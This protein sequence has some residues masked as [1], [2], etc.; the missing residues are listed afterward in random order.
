VT[1]PRTR[2]GFAC[3]VAIAAL[4]GMRSLASEPF[5]HGLFPPLPDVN[6]AQL[7]LEPERDMRPLERSLK[8]TAA[9]ARE[10]SSSPLHGT[11]F[12]VADVIGP[13]RARTIYVVPQY[14]RSPTSP[15]MF[16]SI[17]AAI[18]EVQTNIE[19]LVLHL[20]RRQ[21]LACVGTEG[22]KDA[23]IPRS[24]ELDR[25]A[26]AL[27][28]LRVAAREA[29]VVFPDDTDAR[30]AIETLLVVIDGAAREHARILDGVG[31]A[32]A[33]L[34]GE[35][36]LVRFGLEDDALLARALAI[37]TEMDALYRERETLAPESLSTGADAVRELVLSEYPLYR[38]STLDPLEHALTLLEDKR[39]TL[40]REGAPELATLLTRLLARVRRIVDETIRPDAV[41]ALHAHYVSIATT[42]AQMTANSARTTAKPGARARL[43][44]IDGELERLQA[45]HARVTRAERENVA[46]LRVRAAL[47]STDTCAVVMGAHHERGLVRLLSAGADA[48]GVI[49]VRP[50]APEDVPSAD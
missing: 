12:F 7:A 30:E 42:S 11:R 1:H 8:D 48:P 35:S 28:D 49:V 32:A 44:V 40:L 18:R 38:D 39:M 23:L 50:F 2:I 5:P 34:K 21:S 20:A 37:A 4:A 26:W 14:H 47:S 13:E 36:P 16:T 3:V 29:R 46:S 45:E 25:L 22:D 17:G 19:S 33:R 27:H 24:F 43:R 6:A 41:R 31:M 15:L 10:L 9:R